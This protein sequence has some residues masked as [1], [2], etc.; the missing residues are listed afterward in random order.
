MVRAARRSTALTA[1]RASLRF[2]MPAIGLVVIGHATIRS[3]G[4]DIQ[5]WQ[6]AL[7]L[8]VIAAGFAEKLVPER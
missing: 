4:G 1:L 8:L 2:G 7:G 5:Q 6:F 3:V